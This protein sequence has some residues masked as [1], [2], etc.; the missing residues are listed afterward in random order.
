MVCFVK[1][2]VNCM[3]VLEK[4]NSYLILSYLCL[5][6]F[7]LTSNVHFPPDPPLL[8]DIDK[9]A[10]ILPIILMAM[11]LSQMKTCKVLTILRSQ[12]L[13]GRPDHD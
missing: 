12:S 2:V 13:S 7:V 10:F 1:S 5:S 3:L 8:E 11:E 4:K 9:V 6:I